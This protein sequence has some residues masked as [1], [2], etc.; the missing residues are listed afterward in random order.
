[1]TVRHEIQINAVPRT[2]RDV[3]AIAITA[4]RFAK[5]QRV[6]DD[7]RLIDLETKRWAPI[8][9]DVSELVWQNPMWEPTA[10]PLLNTIASIE[11]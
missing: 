6:A 3:L 8:R 10:K 9:D 2:Y 11:R 1:M 5:M 4:A 7:V